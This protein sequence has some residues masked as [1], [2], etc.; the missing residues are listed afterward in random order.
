MPQIYKSDEN[1]L[2]DSFVQ[3]ART[4]LTG[5]PQDVQLLIHRAS[6]KFKG[7]HPKMTEDLISLLRE[8]PTRATPLR[9]NSEVPLPVDLDSRLQLLKVDNT[10]LSHNLILD[11][12]TE[13]VLRQVIEERKKT[14]ALFKHGLL[15]TKSMLF[16][17]PPGVGKTMTAKWLAEQLNLP[18][19]VLDLTAVMSSFLGRTGNNIRFVLDYAKNTECILLLDEVDAIAKKRDD[20]SEIGELKR[21]VNVLLQEIDDWPST[22]L[23]IAA[24]NHPNLLDSAIWRR[25]EVVVE[26][27][28]P[29]KEQTVRLIKELIEGN[30][31][32]SNTWSKI[33]SIVFKG[34]S[35][36]DIERLITI[37]R[38]SAAIKE[39]ELEGVMKTILFE[40]GDLLHSQKVELAI[41]LANGGIMS[42]RQA[43]ELT[44]ISRDTIRRNLIKNQ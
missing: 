38:R 18:L 29:S 11:K 9:K 23:L 6:K 24:T 33:L 32:D 26:F 15:P 8:S 1:E 34:K 39:I 30:I 3:L 27:D 12:R 13:D 28:N 16:S 22:G 10:K 31:K 42:Q 5:R 7:E 4:A 2:S 25:F 41:E 19:L 35:Y 44:G 37:A 20:T 14:K 40:E 43:S 21:L 36:S 17:G